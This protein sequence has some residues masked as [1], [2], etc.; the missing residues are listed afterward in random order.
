VL[1]P[2]WVRTNL[3]TA[4]RNRP[5]R[6]SYVLETEQMAQVA[7]YK[8]RRAQQR[9]TVAIDPA[10]VADRVCEAVKGNRFYVF[11]HPQ[12]PAIFEERARRIV[13]GENPVA[14]PE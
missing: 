6:F 7:A 1:C 14:P 12:S 11:T 2:S 4:D 8:A 3:S 13:A 10:T 9:T 5:E